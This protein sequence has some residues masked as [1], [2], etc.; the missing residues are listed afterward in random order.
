MVSSH[1][2]SPSIFRGM[3][4]LWRKYHNSALAALRV[5]LLPPLPCFADIYLA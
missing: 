2:A 3:A 1:M 5:C 4:A